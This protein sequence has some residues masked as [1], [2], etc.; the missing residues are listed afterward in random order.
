MGAELSTAFLL[1]EK[2]GPPFGAKLGPAPAFGAKLGGATFPL[3]TKLGPEIPFGAKLAPKIPLAPLG[4]LGAA[5]IAWFTFGV[6]AI[7]SAL[8]G[9]IKSV[10]WFLC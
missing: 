1:G 2:L 10:C 5:P 9:K 3:G 4:V 8:F 6:R 7:F